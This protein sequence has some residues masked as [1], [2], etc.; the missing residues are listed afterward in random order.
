MSRRYSEPPGVKATGP[1][2]GRRAYISS[3]SQSGYLSE[4]PI[5]ED[6]EGGRDLIKEKIEQREEAAARAIVL[7]LGGLW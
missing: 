3:G 1:L 7:A 5:V 2:G 6:D 4:P